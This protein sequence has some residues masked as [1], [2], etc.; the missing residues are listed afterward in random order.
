MSAAQTGRT[1]ADDRDP[2]GGAVCAAREVERFEREGSGLARGALHAVALGHV[3]F[4]A[5]MEI[6]SS[7]RPRRHFVS[8]G[9]AQ[10]RPHTEASG[11]GARAI[12]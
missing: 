11:F 4:S 5:R 8:H 7:I 2:C 10:I 12:A 9:W 6:G 3:R 1:G